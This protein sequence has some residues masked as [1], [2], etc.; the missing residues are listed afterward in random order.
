MRY[1]VI[2]VGLGAIGS[3]LAGELTAR[4]HSVLGLEQYAPVHDRGGYSGESRLFR[5]AYHEG[6]E[7]VPLLRFSRNYF[8]DLDS[9]HSET[10]FHQTG[11]LSIGHPGAPGLEG[12]H[13]SIHRF[14]LDHEEYD[15]ADL[16]RR[17]PQHS[18]ITDEVGILDKNG[19]VLY[20]DAIVYQMQ[21]EARA[22][23]AT[24]LTHEEVV[25]IEETSRGVKIR[26]TQGT[27][28]ADQAIIS[29]GVWSKTLLPQIDPHVSITPISLGWYLVDKPKHYSPSRFPGFIRESNGSHLYGFPC[30]DGLTVKVG[31]VGQRSEVPTPRELP[32]RASGNALRVPARLVTRY[33]TE[34]SDG[35]ARHSMHMDL[36]SRD[37]RP[38]IDRLSS[39]ITVA[40]AF[41]GHGFKLTPALGRA[42]ADLIDDQ[43]PWFSLENFALAR[44]EAPLH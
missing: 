9:R 38:I 11:A 2:I 43:E 20:S 4:G 21:K 10:L 32:P 22:A 3:Y 7:Y 37:H 14:G 44:F 1:S 41:S 16:K 27:Y 19:G 18:D 31:N 5:M 40:T 13:D 30:L 42:V 28:K 39:R 24:L 29:T 33:L 23:G 17:Y 25:G 36:F 35:P 12:V 34:V 6:A 8:L 15:T 26:T